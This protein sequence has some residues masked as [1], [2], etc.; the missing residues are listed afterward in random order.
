M[1]YLVSDASFLRQLCKS[2]PSETCLSVVLLFLLLTL[3]PQT[4]S[5]LPFIVLPPL[6]VPFTPSSLCCRRTKV[7]CGLNLQLSTLCEKKKKMSSK[8]SRAWI[9]MPVIL[10]S[11]A[12]PPSVAAHTDAE[13]GRHLT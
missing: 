1:L 9:I 11:L 5:N 10:R 12:A 13:F 7:D 6:F 3:N 4:K 8:T 2:A